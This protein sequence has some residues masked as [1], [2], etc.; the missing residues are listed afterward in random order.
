[1]SFKNFSWTG[2]SRIIYLYFVVDDIII[3][4]IRGKTEFIITAFNLRRVSY[5]RF[6]VH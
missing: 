5:P 6:R 1:M 2:H 4:I 3:I